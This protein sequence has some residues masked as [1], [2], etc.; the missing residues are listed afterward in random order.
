[1]ATGITERNKQKVELIN[2]GFSLRYI[3][4]WQPK[5][6]L[7]RHKEAYNYEGDMTEAVGTFVP[8]VPGNPDYVLRK[9]KI[10]L[11][12]WKPSSEC[13]CQWC[14]ERTIEESSDHCDLC[15]FV[16]KGESPKA[17]NSSLRM[18][19]FHRHKDSLSKV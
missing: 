18:H 6:I 13:E 5:T 14:I 16:P 11:F 15:D 7:Y 3:D 1:M 10:G 9:A 12:P 2:Q 17:I 4:E 19:V 8:N